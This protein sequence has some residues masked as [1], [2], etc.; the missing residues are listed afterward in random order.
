MTKMGGLGPQTIVKVVVLIVFLVVAW[1]QI[2]RHL[3]G[4]PIEL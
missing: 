2:S 4:N 3:K 1:T